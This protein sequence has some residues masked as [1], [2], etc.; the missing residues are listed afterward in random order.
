MEKFLEAAF[1]YLD[2]DYSPIPIMSPKADME[3]KD[4]NKKPP[5]SWKAFQSR[6]PTQQEIRNWAKQYPTARIA[7]ITGKNTNLTVLDCDSQKAQEHIEEFLPDSLITP[8][9]NTPRGGQHLY[10][11]YEKALPNKAGILPG[12]DIRNDGGYIICPPSPGLNGT[13]YQWLPGLVLG[14]VQPAEM[15]PAL[16][17]YLTKHN[18][19]QETPERNIS[20]KKG[21]R[22]ED[23]FHIALGMA[24]GGMAR[25]EVEKATIQFAQSCNPQLSKQYALT[26]V[27]SAFERL[28]SKERNLTQEVRDWIES[29]E[30]EFLTREVFE[31]LD[32]SRDQKQKVSII[33][34]RLISEGLI[35]RTGR[36]TGCFRRIERELAKMDIFNA[37]TETVD[38]K[39]PFGIENLVNLMPGNIAVIT[40]S[41]DAGKTSLL[42]NI[43][44]DNIDKFKIHYFNSEMGEGELRR[45]LQLFKDFPYENWR[46]ANFYERDQ[47]FH[48]VIVPGK[49]NINIVDYLEVYE[50]FWIARKWIAQIWRKLKGAIA[51]IG[52]QKPY[53][54]DFALGGAGTIEKARL[55]LALESGN[56]KI[57]SAKNWKGSEN[58][59]GKTLKYKIVSGCKLIQVDDWSALE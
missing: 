54:R 48:D 37:N 32:I 33:L 23:L 21:T 43:I 6:K 59:K 36:K 42:L 35:E 29:T 7:L 3:G 28:Q 19:Q 51:I 50:D 18:A 2:R 26:K 13:R 10:F 53:G 24:K 46:A 12:L 15:P 9:A 38:I 39:L 27:K 4:E 31:I 40:G 44:K 47:D 20:F 41:K 52:I 30:G 45:R 56:L 16:L 5:I 22:D 25:E 8:I 34:T 55:Y 11:A 17:S 58:P 57:V 14:E 1:K 49:G